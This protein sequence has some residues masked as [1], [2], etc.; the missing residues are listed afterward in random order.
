MNSTRFTFTPK[1]SKLLAGALTAA[2]A[3]SVSGLSAY[4]ASSATID[5]TVQSATYGSG[6]A[7]LPPAPAAGLPAAPDPANPPLGP[8]GGPGLDGIKTADLLDTLGLSTA[9]LRAALESGRSLSSIAGGQNVDVQKLVQLAASALQA[10][11]SQEYADGRI[12]ESVYNARLSE[13]SSRAAVLLDQTRPQPPVPGTEPAGPAAPDL[14]PGLKDLDRSALA[15]LLGLTS[16]QLAAGLESGQSLADIA[17]ASG[18]NLQG[19]INLA[20]DAL[21]QELKERLARGDLW[22]DE[23][24]AQLQDV[25]TRAADAVKH[26]HPLPPHLQ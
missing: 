9:E 26:H 18:A 24:T 11:L 23:Y 6:P 4:A 20:A 15:G 16:S 3:F 2:L 5:P 25:G 14:G 10:R 19:V 7:A 1:A 8:L 13:A 12:S 21:K 22:T 17:A